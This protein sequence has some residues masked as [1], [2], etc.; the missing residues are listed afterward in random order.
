MFEKRT[1]VM[2]DL[3]ELG[4]PAAGAPKGVDGSLTMSV[5]TDAIP[6]FDAGLVSDLAQGLS[7]GEPE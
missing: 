3:A 2:F 4:V 1:G 5:A 7:D 6:F